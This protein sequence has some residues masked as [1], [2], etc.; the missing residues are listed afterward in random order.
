MHRFYSLMHF[1][2]II[3]NT[4]IFVPSLLVLSACSTVDIM[5]ETE[6]RKIKCTK[7]DSSGRILSKDRK[8][9]IFFTYDKDGLRSYSKGIPFRSTK[10]VIN[11]IGE[12][13]I[14]ASIS[15]INE[16]STLGGGNLKLRLNFSDSV[17]SK[18]FYLERSLD[19]KYSIFNITTIRDTY[20]G[21]WSMLEDTKLNKF[22]AKGELK[23]DYIQTR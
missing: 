7:Y 8:N 22:S 18:G 5:D 19:I 20:K 21:N 11:K 9:P 16:T 15:D 1:K 2:K 17:K 12:N 3:K 4:F 23:C 13:K 6:I 14:D 10:R